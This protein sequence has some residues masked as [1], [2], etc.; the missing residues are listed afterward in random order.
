MLLLAVLHLL[1]AFVSSSFHLL[2]PMDHSH[3]S[4]PA[5]PNPNATYFPANTNCRQKRTA[6]LVM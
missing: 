5:I 3:G 4:F 1:L 6:V 2:I